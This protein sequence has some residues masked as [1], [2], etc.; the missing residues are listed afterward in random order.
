MREATWSKLK[1]TEQ[2]REEL[3]FEKEKLQNEIIQLEKEA[4]IQRKLTDNEKKRL[5]EFV[6]E[7]D[8]LTKMKTEVTIQ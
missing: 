4:E 7:R 6:R 3:E 5:E 2:Q 8:V 1:L